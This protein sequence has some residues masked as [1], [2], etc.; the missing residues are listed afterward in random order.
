MNRKIDEQ[1]ESAKMST[2]WYRMKR[3]W[4]DHK[5]FA[6]DPW[7]KRSAWAWMIEKAQWKD[8]KELARGELCYSNNELAKAWNWEKTRVVRW[9]ASL[10]REGM[11]RTREG[12]S[13]KI[14]TICNYD[15]YQGGKEEGAPPAASKAH[16][17]R[18]STAP[19][20]EERKKEEGR[21]KGRGASAPPAENDLLGGEPKLASRRKPATA[22]PDGFPDQRAL[23]E[24]QTHFAEN[25]MEALS[26]KE[27]AETY[28]TLAIRDDK[29][30]R[31]WRADWRNWYRRQVKFEMERTAQRGGV[32]VL[33]ATHTEYDDVRKRIEESYQP[34]PY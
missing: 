19:H 3:D 12:T 32:K 18:T 11:I 16:Q 26:A 27:V 29:R 13:A 10:S 31:D 5:V 2:D 23:L 20:I 17:H 21:K 4:M 14:I 6:R 30:W 7:N 1:L 33:H 22:I 28:R 34:W 24:A 15:T 9:I 8:G 25:G